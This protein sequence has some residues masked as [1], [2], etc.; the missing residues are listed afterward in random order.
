ML[1]RIQIQRFR[2][3][4]VEHVAATDE[5][6]GITECLG[7]QAHV[8]YRRSHS[9]MLFANGSLRVVVVAS[10]DH[11]DQGG[12]L[13]GLAVF[14]LPLTAVRANPL[15]PL[16]L[17]QNCAKLFAPMRRH[18]DISQ[19]AGIRFAGHRKRSGNNLSCLDRT[20]PRFSQQRLPHR[21]MNEQAVEQGDSTI[22]APVGSRLA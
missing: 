14:A 17:A 21:P 18:E 13:A 12:H 1:F 2:K 10:G 4:H 22:S 7:T 15:T 8:L 5:A 16:R 20:G 9:E 3:M 6:S 19:L 11:S